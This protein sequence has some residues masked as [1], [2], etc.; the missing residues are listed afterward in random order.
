MQSS[1]LPG[2]DVQP[3]QWSWG[4]EITAGADVIHC[5]GVPPAPIWFACS[6]LAAQDPSAS[7]WRR[8]GPK[9]VCCGR[10]PTFKAT[11]IVVWHPHRLKMS[12]ELH[13]ILL[14]LS[15]GR[16]MTQGGAGC[17][18]RML[19]TGADGSIDWCPRDLCRPRSKRSP[20]SLRAWAASSASA[21]PTPSAA[22]LSP[23]RLR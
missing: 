4:C 2:E 22:A 10:D 6:K 19:T 8:N 3:S 7:Y 13:T 16:C 1:T 15:T 18:A 12:E 9:V 21:T 14:N 17:S 5:L 23:L 20:R 11:L